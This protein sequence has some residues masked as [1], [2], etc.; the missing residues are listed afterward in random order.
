MRGIKINYGGVAVGA[1]ENFVPTT[2]DKADFAN[3]N[4]L[5]QESTSFINYG[6]PCDLY[7]VALDGNTVGIPQNTESANIGWWSQQIS[8]ANGVFANPIILTLSA[9]DSHYN[10]SGISLTFD[11]HNNVYST[12]INVKWYDNATLLADS[13]FSP[14]SAFYFCS[15]KVEGYNRIVIQFNSINIPF[16]RLQV[17]AIDYG[18]KITFYGDEL[19]SA[20]IIQE[21]DPLSSQISINTCDFEICSKRQIEYSFQERQSVEVYFN[22]KLR[23]TSF[24]KTAKRKSQNEWSVQAED[25][26]GIMSNSVFYG[27][28]YSN[29]NAVELIKEI[30]NTANVPYHISDLSNE[31]VNGYIP[32]TNCRE[33]LIQVAFAVGAVVDT[34]NSDVVNVFKLSDKISQEIPLDRI[35]QGQTFD[36]ESKITAIEVTSHKYEQSDKV[37]EAYTNKD[38]GNIDNVFVKFSQPLHNL[39]ITN[40]SIVESGTNYA[41]INAN[42]GCK[43]AGKSYEHTQTV[44]KKENPVLTITDMPNVISV[45][46]ATLVSS[47]NVANI[48]EKCYNYYEQNDRVNLKIV[49]GKRK[50]RYGGIKYGIATYNQ[51]TDDI[52]TNV[53]EKITCQSEYLGDINGII[54]KQ[55]Y[56]LNGGIIVKDT[57]MKRGN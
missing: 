34:S 53:G 7:S 36:E 48:L 46:N 4:D 15:K 45:S 51:V 30:F 24:I 11:T 6:N 33:A 42:N 52:P 56:N 17:R 25:Y 39:T 41:I 47:D 13:D 50:A 35:F 8:N 32:Y 31:T 1:K 44:L 18:M 23:S 5:M 10:S 28:V 19:K 54:V 16:N 49:E 14:D 21:I 20:K 38:G 27:D 37:V 22:D 26:I 2:T 57:Q 3:L 40:G 55:T 9:S 12:S 29:K 43:L